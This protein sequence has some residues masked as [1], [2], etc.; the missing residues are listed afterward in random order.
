[1][2][3]E[4]DFSTDRPW[5]SAA[6]M[7]CCSRPR[8]TGPATPRARRPSGAWLTASSTWYSNT[9]ASTTSRI[10]RAISWAGQFRR[11]R[12]HSEL[13]TGGSGA[14]LR[15]AVP[16]LHAGHAPLT[17]PS[18]C[19]DY[20]LQPPHGWRLLPVPARNEAARAAPAAACTSTC[21]TVSLDRSPGPGS[22]QGTPG[23]TPA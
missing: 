13:K 2:R 16:A 5:T 3:V 11:L 6:S 4:F 14:P 12:V 21:R 17:W 1:M 9:R 23:E 7:P 10:T 15:P 20:Q 22:V 8:M 19:P 18:A